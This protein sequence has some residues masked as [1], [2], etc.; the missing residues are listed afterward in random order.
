MD[1]YKK[2]EL[3]N[4][5]ATATVFPASTIPLFGRT[6]YFL[7]AVVFTLKHTFLS[8]GLCSLMVD[9]TTS[10]NGPVF[11]NYKAI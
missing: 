5:P 3:Q 8:V 1:I 6:Q 2:E 7:G 11:F 10:V 9:E 4:I